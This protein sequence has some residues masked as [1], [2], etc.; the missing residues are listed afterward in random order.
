MGA[1]PT[2]PHVE[3]IRALRERTDR[4]TRAE[5]H[6]NRVSATLQVIRMVEAR[7]ALHPGVEV[8]VPGDDIT[9]VVAEAWEIPEPAERTLG[10]RRQHLRLLEATLQP[11]LVGAQADRA[12]MQDLLEKQRMALTTRTFATVARELDLLE[13]GWSDA[14]AEL[15]P[16]QRQCSV[17]GPLTV[18]LDQGGEA[19]ERAL[20]DGDTLAVWRAA[21]RVAALVKSVQAVRDSIGL[22]FPTPTLDPLPERPDP[23]I[24]PPAKA[25]REALDAVSS[26]V[27]EAH[28]EAA[29]NAARSAAE[30]EALGQKV[31]AITG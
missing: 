3:Q 11:H 26:H 13:R 5:V 21:K 19:L 29:A 8:D 20:E 17:L 10:T 30:A 25:L 9:A 31:R 24:T 27:R 22:D 16:L 6:L 23:A 12:K 2:V 28:S 18:S 4:A 1:A 7:M 14:R 15:A